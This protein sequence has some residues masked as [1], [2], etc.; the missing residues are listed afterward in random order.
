MPALTGLTPPMTVGEDAVHAASRSLDDKRTS[1]G[2]G[3]DGGTS[4]R[5]AAAPGPQ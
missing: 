2:A 4:T 3:D 5:V 1:S